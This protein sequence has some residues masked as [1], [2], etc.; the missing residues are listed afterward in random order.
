MLDPE[1][2]SELAKVTDPDQALVI[3]KS[4]IADYEVDSGQFN[5]MKLSGAMMLMDMS[6][7]NDR[8][9]IDFEEQFAAAKEA[10]NL[11]KE[12]DDLTSQS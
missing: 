9:P 8:N 2:I 10:V 4:T 3:L 12:L 7:M 6:M 5:S 1:F 11:K